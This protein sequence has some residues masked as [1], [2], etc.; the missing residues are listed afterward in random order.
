MPGEEL[1][2]AAPRAVQLVSEIPTTAVSVGSGTG[3]TI[4]EATPIVAE[5]GAGA[6]AVTAGLVVAPGAGGYEAQKKTREA[7]AIA[8]DVTHTWE[9]AY[10]DVAKI[11]PQLSGPKKFQN[12]NYIEKTMA[13]ELDKIPDI[14]KDANGH[15]DLTD[16]TTL[17]AING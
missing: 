3:T 6:A 14:K 11:Q 2:L 9:G 5:A 13:P 17:L 8:Q 12:F 15:Y 16:K 7:V 1:V 10:N 4:V